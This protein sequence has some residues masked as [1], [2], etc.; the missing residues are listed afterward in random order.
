M[1]RGCFAALRMAAFNSFGL[2]LSYDLR[3]AFERTRLC[4]SAIIPFEKVLFSSSEKFLGRALEPSRR[5]PGPRTT[6]RTMHCK[7]YALCPL[8]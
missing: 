3:L 6:F 7:R 1:E 4:L 2:E 8:L 5:M